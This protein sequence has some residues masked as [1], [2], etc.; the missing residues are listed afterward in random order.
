MKEQ[1]RPSPYNQD[2]TIRFP[3]FRPTIIPPPAK[4]KKT[5][6]RGSCEHCGKKELMGFTCSYCD[7]YFCTE[8]RL[9]EKHACIGLR[10][11]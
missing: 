2:Y 5:T 4:V 11:Q 7:G 1:I 8:H 3:S 10:R 9:P 6:T